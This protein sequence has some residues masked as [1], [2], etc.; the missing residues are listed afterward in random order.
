SNFASGLMIALNRPFE[1]G[2]YV[3]LNDV[4]GAVREMNMIATTLTT[5]DN[6]KLVIPNKLVWGSTITNFNTLGKRRVYMKVGVA[7]G[8]DLALAR[9]VA[10]ETAAALPG[11]LADVAPVAEVVSLDDSAVTMTVRVWTASADY[12]TCYWAGLPALARAFADAQISIPFPQ[13]D[14]HVTGLKQD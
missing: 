5:P 14:V 1:V 11:V 6:K 2:D 8:T 9:K 3:K 4:E 12:W 13:M 7:Y 10:V